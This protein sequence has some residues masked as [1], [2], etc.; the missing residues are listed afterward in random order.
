MESIIDSLNSSD[1]P[2]SYVYPNH[3]PMNPSFFH[4]KLCQKYDPRMKKYYRSSYLYKVE[5]NDD[6]LYE[7]LG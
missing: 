7:N 5:R 6:E 4:R 3:I 2:F 1:P